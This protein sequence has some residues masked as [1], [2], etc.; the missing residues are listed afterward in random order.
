[1]NIRVTSILGLALLAMTSIAPGWAQ[2]APQAEAISSKLLDQPGVAKAEQTELAKRDVFPDATAVASNYVFATGTAGSLTDMSTGTTQLVAADSD[3]TASAV[4]AI[5]FD[6]YFQG[7]RQSEF[8]ANS[9]GLIRLGATKVQGGSPYQPLGQN[10]IPL[11]SAYGAD[12]RVHTSGKVHYKLMGAEPNRQLVIE[13]LNMQANWNSGGTADL[14]YQVRLSES[15]GQIEFVYGSM[16]MSV[17]GAA[18]GNSRDPNFGFSSSN[19]AGTVGSVT[20]PQSGTPSPTFDGASATA[21]GNLYTAGSIDVLTSAADGSRRT[22][23]FSPAVPDAPTAIS[24]TA[25]SALAM[26][27]NWV[28]SAN[29][30]SYAVYSS[31]DGTNYTYTGAAAQDATSYSASGLLPN[32]N[33]FWRVFAVS[34]GALSTSLSGSQSTLPVGAIASTAVGGNWSD[35][36]TWVGNAVPTAADNV[37]IVDGATVTID[38]AAVAYSVT[39]GTGGTPATLQWDSAAA[40]T[41]AVNTSVNIAANGTFAT[42]GSGTITGHVVSI[43]TDLNDDGVLDFSTNSNTA[44]AGI[45]F[46]SPANAVFGGMGTADLRS[47]TVAKGNVAS[48]VE[49][50]PATLTVQGV[51]TDSAGFLT[52]TSGTIRL[53]GTFTM[54]NRVFAVP[55]YTIS[56]A[57]GFWL[58]NPNFVVA[59]QNASGTV[60]GQFKVSNGT[61][62]VGTGT[63]NSLGFS[64]GSSIVIE[65]GFVNASGRFGVASAGSAISY[66]QSGGV[67]TACTVGNTSSTLASFDLGT[68][69]SSNISIS[70][71]TMVIQL[72]NT[73][74]SG[75]R[76]YRNS[77][78]SG[79]TGVTGGTLQLGNA[80]SGAAK[81]F[82]IGSVVPNLVIDGTSAGHS[83]LF[84]PPV[85]Y[86]DISLDMTINPGTTLNMYNGVFLFNGTTITNNGTIDGT[87]AATRLIFFSTNTANVYT[88]SGVVTAPLPSLEL[89]NDIGLTIDPASP[90][91]PVGRII[92]FSG[93]FTNANKLTLGNGAATTGIIQIGN[94][95]T[96]TDG[97]TFD[98]PPAFNLGSGGQT[99]SYLRTTNSKIIGPEVNPTRILTSLTIDDNDSTHTLTVTGGPLSVAGTLALTNGRVVSATNTLTANAS[100]TVTRTSGY[101]DGNFSKVYAAA[102]S[103]T[104]EVGTENGYSPVS[105]NAASGTFPA[106][107]TVRAIQASVPGISPAG[108]AI[109]RHWNLSAPG[110]TADLVFNYLDPLDLPVTVTEANLLLYRQDGLAF[111][112]L[113]ATLDTGA[114]TASVASV[115]TFGVF[116]LAEP[117]AVFVEEAD[118][119][120]TLTDGVTTVDTGSALTYTLV[121]SNNGPNA[122]IGASVNDAFPA[123]L[124]CS[125]TC[126]ASLGAACTAAGSGDIAD[127][128]D[129]PLNSNVTYTASC[130]VAT[131]S[132]NTTLVNTATIAVPSGI[133][134]PTPGNNSATDTDALVRLSDLSISK[135]N[136]T[137]TVVAGGSTTYTIVVG[138]AG[139][140][141]AAVTTSDSFPT[142]LTCTWTCAATNGT[143]TAAGSGNIADAGTVDMGGTLTY[144]AACAVSVN[145][146]GS[147]S[148]TA[149]V[150]LDGV[151]TADPDTDNNSA[152]DIDTVVGV[153]D[154]GVSI[155]DN[156]DFVKVGD[157]LNY[158][159]IVGNPV[160]PSTAAST[161]NDTLPA[162]LG[163][164]SWICI[165]FGGAICSGG[166]GNVLNDNAILPVGSQIAYVYSVNVQAVSAT[167]LIS[168][169][170]T[171]TTAGDSNPANDSAT[172]VDT[173]V[174]FVDGFDGTTP[175]Q[176]IEGLGNGT[177]FVGATFR[178]DP[179]LT[180][181]LGITPTTVAWGYSA[182]G[183]QLFSI[184]LARFGNDTVMRTTLS[185]QAGMPNRSNWTSADVA[186]LPLE[187][188]WQS[189]S[190]QASDGYLQLSG[191]GAPIQIAGLHNPDRL[192]SMRVLVKDGQ[193]WMTLLSH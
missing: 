89:Q 172:D 186:Q 2:S 73:A 66:T 158:I 11:I 71:G 178:V 180:G 137:S 81:S 139:G 12:Q 103:K 118:L 98:V 62:N 40:R 138:N 37:T 56:A 52:L 116:T 166:S 163:G 169:T 132:S 70:G 154:V 86:N 177:D 108:K 146:V 164:G 124:T 21:V 1:M 50:K 74:A 152:T 43:G 185:D 100:A 24:F 47:L 125:W 109:D 145:A 14:T 120:V 94:T 51:D 53:G 27:V 162:E 75:P 114:N 167:D 61:F 133:T 55:G 187:L 110:V 20:A 149:T 79:I 26:T 123:D 156:R 6:F 5:G 32:T 44:G 18:D 72:A 16:D 29:E 173:L 68:S 64:T 122:V 35:P 144:T 112:D 25:I 97:G 176:P 48:V 181:Q 19:T 28:D 85:N 113:G 96:P 130:A 45:S 58:D 160:G 126:S 31:T 117:G 128:V 140:N 78:G 184:E 9:N 36:N 99:I 192:V 143:C 82:K 150:T 76:D 15:T 190:N 57:A 59:A 39:I 60:A 168:N 165:P 7:V 161:V 107:I 54:T 189:A 191:A 4:T 136:G 183:A 92:I 105:V 87:G 17:L 174:I 131:A 147:L 34:E 121:A 95:T 159:I 67:I 141:D 119:E 193:P 101:V 8:S 135:T 83:A 3:D 153:Y 151:S 46:V 22:F 80:A 157:T 142:G 115:S 148:N 88:G 104:I 13:F 175:T 171:V 33:Y 179:A 63:G 23:A 91:I 93:S 111:T 65:G 102:G 49:V 182:S 30:A 90:N 38:T 10:G 155:S 41:L 134:D 188:F 170:V 106:D 42:Q 127:L 84:L 69:L 77:A 129:L